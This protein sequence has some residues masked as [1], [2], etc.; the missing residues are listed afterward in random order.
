MYYET[1]IAKRWRKCGFHEL[2]PV[3]KRIGRIEALES[4]NLCIPHDIDTRRL[5]FSLE[6]GEAA[7]DEG[8]MRFAGWREVVFDAEMHLNGARS[9]PAAAACGEMGRLRQHLEAEDA[10]VEA[11]RALFFPA[12]HRKLDMIKSDD[13]SI[14]HVHMGPS[15][16]NSVRDPQ[17]T[18][19]SPCTRVALRRIGSASLLRTLNAVKRLLV[20]SR[21]VASVP[22]R[23]MDATNRLLRSAVTQGARSPE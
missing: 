10:A 22:R 19:I 11:L 9:E 8:R 18:I 4:R 17:L 5:E 1:L 16:L 20:D 12:R 2:E 3:A 23:V 15:P 13:E 14:C 7:H 21:S 6:G